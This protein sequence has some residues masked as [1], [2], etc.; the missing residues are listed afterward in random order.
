MT[1]C[2][3]KSRSTYQPRLNHAGPFNREAKTQKDTADYHP[4]PDQ[5][6]AGRF[7]NGAHERRD[8]GRRYSL[9]ET[10][11]VKFIDGKRLR[12]RRS[13]TRESKIHTERSQ[14]WI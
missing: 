12:S 6:K 10:I 1:A 4:G 2:L 11:V 9:E 14:W 5:R 13:R 8:S 7:R 3:I